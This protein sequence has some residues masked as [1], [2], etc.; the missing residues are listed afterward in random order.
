MFETVTV[1]PFGVFFTNRNKAMNLRGHSHFAE[2][3]VTFL[4]TQA[5]E[6]PGYPS[7]AD[8][9][10]C[11]RERLTAALEHPI[12]GTNEDVARAL[13]DAAKGFARNPP[14]EALAFEGCA[15]DLGEL[16]LAVR[17]V[18]DQIGHDDSFTRYRIQR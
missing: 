6:R 17:G 18:N 3:T 9:N 7:F 12:T 8:T 4:N 2:V 5:P 10:A 1:G 15:W 11:L 13:W 16:E 14:P